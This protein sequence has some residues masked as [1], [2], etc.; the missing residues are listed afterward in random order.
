[1]FAEERDK[2]RLLD[3]MD[4]LISVT[5]DS[6]EAGDQHADVVDDLFPGESGPHA[7]DTSDCRQPDDSAAG[8]LN[9][10]TFRECEDVDLMVELRQHFEQV[11]CGDRCATMLK[12]GLRGEDEDFHIGCAF[13]VGV[14]SAIIGLPQ[15]AAQPQRLGIASSMS[16]KYR[17][18]ARR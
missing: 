7:P 2:C 6:L 13:S 16:A 15:R 18:R 1:M 17:C 10:F 8:N 14:A 4:E 5:S 11:A 9:V 3:R 12:E